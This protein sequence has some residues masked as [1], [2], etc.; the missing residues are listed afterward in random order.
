[1]SKWLRNEGNLFNFNAFI[2]EWWF[3]SIEILQMQFVRRKPIFRVVE[4][5]QILWVSPKYKIHEYQ[6]YSE[7][8]TE[9][10]SNKYEK[11]LFPFSMKFMI[12]IQENVWIRPRRRSVVTKKLPHVLTARL[13]HL[14][15]ISS[16]YFS[17]SLALQCSKT[18]FYP[19]CHGSHFNVTVLWRDIL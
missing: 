14:T 19:P 13:F 9:H 8:I 15:R 17:K 4:F 12:E 16:S 6:V 10:W 5:S 2:S 1:M 3:M 18:H 7:W 11:I